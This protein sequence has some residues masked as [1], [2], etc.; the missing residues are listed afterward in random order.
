[1]PC[2]GSAMMSSVRTLG[3]FKERR[4]HGNAHGF[5]SLSAIPEEKITDKITRRVLA[6]QKGMMVWWKIG[7]GT[8]VAAHSHP[9]EQLVWMVKG[10]ME[11][12]IDKERRVLEAGGIA[13]I[14][15]GVEHEAGATRTPRWSTYSHRRARIFWPAAGRHGYARSEGRAKIL[16]MKPM[17]PRRQ[18]HHVCCSLKADIV[19][20]AARVFDPKPT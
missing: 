1:M 8:H 14:P 6:G 9:H 4:R 18:W 19:S 15:G 13:A 20:C 17:L 3:Q 10:R 2:F 5:R 16:D 7:A 11:F 12:R